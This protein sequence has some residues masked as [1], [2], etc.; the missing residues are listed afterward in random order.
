M[1]RRT[2]I[3]FCGLTR[4]EDIHAAVRHGADAMGFVFHHPPSSREVSPEVARNLI[5][6]VPPFV[7][8]VGLLVN[9]DADT[10]RDLLARVPL[11]LLQFHGDEDD[12]F[13][14]SFGRPFI[15]AVRVKPGVDLDALLGQWPSARGLLL[16]AWH[17]EQA[18]GTGLT[19]DWEKIPL[20]WRG[21]IILAGGLTPANVADAI[22][23][24]RPY[25]VDV[26]GGIEARKGEKDSAL[27]AAFAA[28]VQHEDSRD[29]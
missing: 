17:P 12:A 6:E 28:A 25:G 29:D 11:D 1:T 13:C 20:R 4:P 22:R 14:A 3:K 16:D 18:G 7:T 2:R 27:M 19:F 15:K 26:S 23:T 21:R 10:V 5:R 8:T 24:I 9:P